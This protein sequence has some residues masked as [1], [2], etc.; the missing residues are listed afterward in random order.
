MRIDA[1]RLTVTGENEGNLG[2]TRL[3]EA[4][5]RVTRRRCRG[6]RSLRRRRPAVDVEES[7]EKGAGRR[8]GESVTGLVGARLRELEDV[9]K[10]A[11]V[12][13]GPP[14]GTEELE[15]RRTRVIDA[16]DV[17]N[18]SKLHV[19]DQGGITNHGVHVA[20]SEL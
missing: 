18:D 3:D 14:K 2:S 12:V 5:A 11:F 10:I 6:G 9:T 8:L 7:I 19:G 16:F 20:Q 17:D 1:T 13:Q 15:Q 4:L